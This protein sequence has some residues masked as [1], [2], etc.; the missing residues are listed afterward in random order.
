MTKDKL[1]EII[2]DKNN[3]K[4]GNELP[5]TTGYRLCMSGNGF[6]YILQYSAVHKVWNTHDTAEPEQ[7]ESTGTNVKFWLDY[8][9]THYKALEDAFAQSIG[10]KEEA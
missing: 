5:K 6:F 4:S 7:V 8:P 9:A 10:L 1:K 2:F 3:W